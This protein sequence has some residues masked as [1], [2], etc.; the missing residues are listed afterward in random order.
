[1]AIHDVYGDKTRVTGL[2][3]YMGHTIAACGA[4]ETIITLMMMKHGFIPPTLNLDT[5]DES[6][7]MINHT[8]QVLDETINTA[9]VQNFAFGGVNTALVLKKFK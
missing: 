7:A 1:M 5:V 8:Q 2:K 9:S 6:C 3:S 4:I